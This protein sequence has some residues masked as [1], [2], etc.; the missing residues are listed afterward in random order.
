[1]LTLLFKLII[2]HALADY[3]LQPESMARG[4][5]RQTSGAGKDQSPPWPYWLL[6]HSLIHGGAVWLLTGIPLFGLIETVIHGIIDVSKCEGRISIHTDQGIHL[7][8]KVIYAAVI[9]LL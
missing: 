1:M 4:K 6:A 8:C 9:V 5:C 2:G 7:L 3:A